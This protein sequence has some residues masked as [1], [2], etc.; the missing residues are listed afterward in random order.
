MILSAS[1]EP[2]GLTVLLERSDV[3]Q[4]ELPDYHGSA[5]PGIAQHSDA[6]RQKLHARIIKLLLV[7]A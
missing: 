3:L 4:H 2:H 7:L 5:K 1:V 6:L